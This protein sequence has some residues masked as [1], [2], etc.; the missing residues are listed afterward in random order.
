MAVWSRRLAVLVVLALCA[1]VGIIA[2]SSGGGGGAPTSTSDP[3][4]GR[5]LYVDPANAAAA[6]AAEWRAEGRDADA[7]LILKIAN[8]PTAIWV[9]GNPA[10]ARA[11]VEDV[12]VKA[13]TAKRLPVLVA[14]DIPFRDCG[15]YS[16]GGASSA[17]AYRAWVKA[18]STGLGDRPA[19]VVVEPDAV[20][21]AVS[22]C[23]S[24]DR[25]A[26][27]Y[28]LLRGAVTAFGAHPNVRVY[29]D[30]GNA[31]W[32][33]PPSRMIQPLRAA[34]VARADGFALNV[35]NFYS[36]EATL[37]YG[38]ALSDGLGKAHFVIDTG[39]NGN[40]P[41]S[42]ND[43]LRWCNPPGRALGHAPTTQTRESRVDAFLW[44]KQ[45]GDS[46]GACRPGAPPAGRWW[47]SY[48]LELARATPHA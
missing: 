44:V 9:A 29:L 8:Q 39:R 21:H 47:A 4:A 2:S 12:T 10:S 19:I 37:R 24:A 43:A 36:T 35:S 31:G 30:A 5:R 38:K 18:F 25:V 26:G 42:G 14:Y 22:G 40:G 41:E 15:N 28:Q 3:V 34:G 33:T 6:Q 27:R 45:P 1:L 13:A 48:A 32:I 17:V 20:A 16:S 7:A 46:D 23:L 11:K